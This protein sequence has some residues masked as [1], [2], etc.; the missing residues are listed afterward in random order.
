MVDNL[1]WKY[2]LQGPTGKE[3]MAISGPIVQSQGELSSGVS[4]VSL[5]QNPCIGLFLNI[6]A[7]HVWRWKDSWHSIRASCHIAHDYNQSYSDTMIGRNR[8]RMV[9]FHRT[10]RINSKPTLLPLVTFC[11][12]DCL[13]DGLKTATLCQS[14]DVTKSS[15]RLNRWFVASENT[16]TGWSSEPRIWGSMP[17]RPREW[18]IMMKDNTRPRHGKI[19]EKKENESF[20]ALLL[21]WNFKEISGFARALV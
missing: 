18:E 4:G 20:C 13:S 3:I 19:F 5:I 9:A 17:T 6:T 7:N 10:L 1:I 2:M 15:P 12:T 11:S 8:R 16:T 21:V 14:V